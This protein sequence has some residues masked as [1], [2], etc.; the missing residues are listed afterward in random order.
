MRFLNPTRVVKWLPKF[1]YQVWLLAL[2]RLLSQLGSGFTLFNAPIFFTT[3]VGLS[4]TL[5]GIGIGSASISGVLGRILGGSLADSPKWGR[6]RT[7]MLALVVSA[8]ASFVIAIASNFPTF[9]IGNLLM[10]FGIGLYWPANE[11]AVADLTAP[12][13][14]NEAYAI[15]RLADSIGLGLG[16]VLGGWLVSTAKALQPEL[17]NTAYR[18][19]FVID[20]ITFLV[21]LAVLYWAIAETLQPQTQPRRAGKGWRIALRDR[22]L[23]VYAL[24]NILLTTY[25]IQVSSTMPL[26]FSDFVPTG[27]GSYGF[28]TA[29]ISALFTW[30]IA[31]SIVCQIP[32]ARLLN[33]L[34]RPHSLMISSLL[35]GIGFVLVWFTGVTTSGNLIWAILGLGI[36]AF[37][38]AAYMPAASSLVVELAPDSLRG[39]Y[40]AVN[41][42]CW[43][44]GYFIG[45]PLGGW[46]LD[47]PRPLA[48][49]F[50]L[51]TAA[52]AV[53]GLWILQYL[54]QLMRKRQKQVVD[55]E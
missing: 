22:A 24:V 27:A 10:G 1:S 3:E 42:Q 48:D 5:V 44:I 16:V 4:R 38:T 13:Q 54:Q 41:S 46:A 11:A 19:L 53:I 55:S 9:L 28:E 30:H 14:R 32:V 6:K 35:W 36:L 43:A 26:Y 37:A 31:L 25:L 45:P 7:L 49:N 2:G 47:Q 51:A 40:L 15:T 21:F 17:V 12:E 8:I 23:L 33:R 34:S 18:S 20:G 50:W 29:T 39:I 52:S